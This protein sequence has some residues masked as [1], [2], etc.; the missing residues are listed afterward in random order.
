MAKRPAKKPAKR[1]PKKRATAKR[2]AKPKAKKKKVAAKKKPA[3]KPRKR[4][5][6][7]EIN[8][9]GAAR[10]PITVEPI[11]GAVTLDAQLSDVVSSELEAE[12][13]LEAGNTSRSIAIYSRLIETDTDTPLASHL[14]ARGRAYYRAGDFDSAIGDF[15]R[16]LAI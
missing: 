14:V 4:V 9:I 8:L 15:E 7:P 10:E 11:P 5:A 3:A 6:K 12:A 1:A 2:A 16:G 13:A